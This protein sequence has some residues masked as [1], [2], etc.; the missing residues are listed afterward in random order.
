MKEGVSILAA[1]VMAAAASNV[2]G[3]PATGFYRID[4]RDDGRWWVVSP[5]GS[6][7]FM[8]GIDHA[9]WNGH[10]CEALNTNP[11]RDEMAKKFAGDQAAWEDETLSRLKAWGFTM[12]GNGCSEELENR[13]LAHTVFLAMGTAF[14]RRGPGHD[15]AHFQGIPGS[16][17]P[18]VFHPDWEKFC[19]E[20]AARLCAPQRDNPNLF[21]Y[22]FDNELD[23]SG[24]TREEA[25][26]YFGVIAD[27]IRRHDP[28]HLLLGCRFAGLN[29]AKREIWEEAGRVCDA[30]T[31]NNYPWADLD[32]NVILTSRTSGIRAADAYA[33]RHAWT[34]KPLIITEWGYSALDSGLPCSGGAGQRFRTQRERVAASELCARTLMSIPFIV[35][36]DYFMWVDEPAAGISVK[37]PEDTNY[38]LVDGRGEPYGELTAMFARIHPEAEALHAAGKLP[39]E[40]TAPPDT[41][42]R[43]VD[44]VLDRLGRFPDGD[45]SFTRGEDGAYHVRT[46]SG[47][48]LSGR[49]GGARMIESIVLNGIDY[50]SFTAMLYHGDWQDIERV[51]AV[52]WLP[53]GGTLRVAGEASSGAK[54]FRI[55]C[56][57]TPVKGGRPWLVCNVVRVD[58]IGEAP[59]SKASVFP[60]QY[61]P[62]AVDKMSGGFRFA[63]NVWKQPDADVWMRSS[64]GAWCGAATTSPL[65]QVFNYR[66]TSDR[67][68]HPDILMAPPE[69]IEIA[70]GES[71]DPEGRMWIV[72]GFG[73]GGVAGWQGFLDDISAR[74]LPGLSNS[75]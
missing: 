66:V 45:A 61:C 64:D 57:I 15:L 51:T 52:E 3:L 74:F 56:D 22:F 58:N 11:Y 48:A 73:G 75:K 50:G 69:G 5:D 49:V 1:A 34:G 55:V 14:C 59:L 46:K 47:L 37:F 43:T 10:F 29:S 8:R 4:R 35:G 39:V 63:Q 40:R 33:E 9:N 30:V 16:G 68:Q 21:G 32:R 65:L 71:Y 18:N 41:A 38:G 53:D 24:R 17:F 31:F 67:M 25:A 36:Y 19:D 42:P 72:A 6:D 7:T 20:R 44:K 12:L 2:F 70:P 60:R 28:N 13:G 26:R 62:W 23:W 27:A 54:T